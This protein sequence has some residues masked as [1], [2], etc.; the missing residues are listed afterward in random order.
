MWEQ[1]NKNA[2]SY[3]WHDWKESNI[4]ETA[5]EFNEILKTVK[6]ECIKLVPLT[7]HGHLSK[8]ILGNVAA[9]SHTFSTNTF[10][11]IC[12]Y[13]GLIYKFIF[14]PSRYTHNGKPV[15]KVSG[16]QAL[17]K[18]RKE[19]GELAKEFALKENEE[20]EK[21]KAQ[22]QK[23]R[24]ELTIHAKPGVVF[25]SDDTWTFFHLDIH[26]AYPA[27]IAAT[28]P[29]LKKY[30]ETLYEQKEAGDPDAKMLLNAGIGAM[31]SLKLQGRRYPELSRRGIEW[32]NQELSRMAG[33]LK[34]RDCVILSYN[35][36]GIWAGSRN[37]IPYDLPGLGDKLG[38]WD[39][40]HVV[41]KLRYKS[42]GAYEYIENGVYHPVI[43]GRTRLDA[44]KNREHWQ[45]GDIFHHDATVI[46]YAF[47]TKNLMLVEV[48]DNE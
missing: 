35:T 42:R 29:E 34:K 31:Q 14:W 5:E 30:M 21:V 1:Y 12:V 43:R 16:R 27:G 6:D 44:V 36:D 39:I 25:E 7:E 20:V 4:I 47:D 26:S 45:W 2:F 37:G 3:N 19:A 40:D 10:E 33:E 15:S 38:E 17:N 41:E 9:I 32:T 23:P 18:F 48:D 28:T 13:C 24:I 46:K 11:I 22:I 8:R